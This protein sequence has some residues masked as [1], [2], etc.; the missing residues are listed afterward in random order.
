MKVDIGT[1]GWSYEHWKEKFYPKGIKS[2]ERLSFYSKS[3]ST[4]EINNSFYNL[5]KEETLI[6][7]RESVPEN[8]VFSIKANRYLTHIR[9]L[10]AEEKSVELFFSRVKVLGPKMGPVL[11]QLPPNLSGDVM[12]FKQFLKL[13]PQKQK[14]VFEFRND[15]WYEQEIFNIFKENGLTLC[16]HDHSDAP[17][18]LLITSN[19]LYIRMHGPSGSYSGK[20]SEKEIKTLA[21]KILNLKGE[22]N[23]VYCYFNDDIKGYAIEN[24]LLLKEIVNSKNQEEL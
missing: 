21:R 10:R 11:F 1:S 13:L 12:L 14:V 4:V 7:W 24:A 3:F 2:K 20:Y 5:P 16:F 19:I 17:P 15:S 8:F 6:N 18:P 22:V 9:R 23:E